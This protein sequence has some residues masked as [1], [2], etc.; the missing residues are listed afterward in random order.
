MN[1]I[2]VLIVDDE[3]EH[4]KTLKKSLEMTGR[5]D[6]LVAMK[7]A[8]AVRLVKSQL[9]DVIVLDIMMPEMSGIEVAEALRETPVTGKIPIIFL[10]ALLTK[11]EEVHVGAGAL[12]KYDVVAKPVDI[13]NLIRRIEAAAS[14]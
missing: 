8:T 5:F 14:S 7:G 2:K 3:E 1:K 6:V 11:T 4:C 9:P 12:Q 13:A 10:T